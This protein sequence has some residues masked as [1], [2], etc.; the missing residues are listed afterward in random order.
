[1]QDGDIVEANPDLSKSKKILGFEPKV[2][3]E[4]GIKKFVDWFREYHGLQ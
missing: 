2:D 1:M 4:D 3:F